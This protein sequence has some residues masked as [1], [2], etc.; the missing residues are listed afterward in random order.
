MFK[1]ILLTLFVIGFVSLN[2]QDVEV[3]QSAKPV[4]WSGS[5]GTNLTTYI[6]RGQENRMNPFHYGFFGSFNLNLYE[7]LDIPVSF[8]YNQFGL[9][10]EKPF[11]QL[12]MSPKYKWFQ[13]HLGHRNM[14]FNQY[15]L[16]GHTFYG[17]GAE[18]TPGK[19]R[20]SAMKGRLRD[21]ILVD[22]R[23]GQQLT[24]P[25]FKRTGW[26]VKAGIGSFRNFVDLMIFKA[27]DDAQSIE[28]WQDSLYQNVMSGQTGRFTPSENMI[29]GLTSKFSISNVIL[30]LD[31][32]GSFF[33]SDQT[34]DLL[35]KEYKIYSPRTSS[36]FRYAGKTSISFPLGP[37]YFTSSYE[38]VLPDYFTMGAYN[39]VNDVENI[40]VSPSGNFF[41]GKFSVSGMIGTQRNNLFGNRSETTKRLISNLNAIIMPE[42]HY[43]INIAYTNF[44]FNQQV[45]AI[46]LDDSLLIK[47]VNK[48]I[49][50][51]PY[52]NIIKDSTQQHNFQFAYIQQNAEDLNP[53]TRDFGTLETFMFTAGYS[54]VK[55]KGVTLNTGINYTKLNSPFIQNTLSGFSL[56]VSKNIK[57]IQFNLN[58]QFNSS[59]ISGK[60]DGFLI[61]TGLNG[62]FNLSERQS[63]RGNLNWL[64]SSSK[65]F[66]SYN[67][68]IFQ[69]GYNIRLGE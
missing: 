12:G 32:G 61:N 57:T 64:N 11:Y 18:L 60:R 4:T 5:L 34:S 62:N 53:V 58:S 68:V 3:I 14:H 27:W 33:T 20:I 52:Y 29:I 6:T 25:Q 7:T 39:F 15:S 31:A 56:G 10:V 13:L 51:M 2:A 24:D 36:N 43:G 40:T 69:L 37:L 8:N 54:Y 45:Q 44:T 42:S 35:E 30:T 65:S 47:Q 16:A 55:T 41:N 48:S 67:E 38:R 17:V 22:A 1:N 26:G 9:G 59:S 21:Q 23:T 63:F 46:I 50:I 28:S 66:N 19:I 49:T